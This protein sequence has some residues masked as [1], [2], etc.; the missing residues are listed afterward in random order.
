M[1]YTEKA[2]ALRRCQAVRADGQPCKAWAI[3]GTYRCSAHTYKTRRTWPPG[4]GPN[5][6]G[7]PIPCTCEAYAWPHK[8]GGGL[9]RWPDPPIYRCTTP[10]HSHDEPRIR[11]RGMALA[12]RRSRRRF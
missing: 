9:C 12:F 1:A 6:R 11:W 7:R 8:P 3:W 4:R 10:E 2:K 5:D